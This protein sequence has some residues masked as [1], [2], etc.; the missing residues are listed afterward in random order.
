MPTSTSLF[1]RI[2]GDTAVT[3]TVIKLYDK[4]LSDEL[5]IPFFKDIDVAALRRSQ[6]AFVTVA[7]GGPHHYSGKNM[8][9]AHSTPRKNG[10]KNAHFDRVAYHLKI[11]MMELNVPT[12][13][14]GEALSIVETTRQDIVSAST[15]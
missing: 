8:H 10:L 12:D 14:I 4:I 3:A 11:S 7:F 6:I 1:D 13:L 5:L 2:G 9:D 15:A